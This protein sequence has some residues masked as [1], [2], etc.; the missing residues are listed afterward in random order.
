MD[1]PTTITLTS[2]RGDTQASFVVHNLPPRARLVES[3]SRQPLQWWLGSPYNGTFGEI[4]VAGYI[5]RDCRF[6]KRH[7]CA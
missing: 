3:S 2:A 1:N 7:F 4:D 5:Q 6:L